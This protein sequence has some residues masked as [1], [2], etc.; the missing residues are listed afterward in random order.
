MAQD[1]YKILEVD[2]NATEADIKKAYRRLA[3]KH[4]PDVN[5]ND[6]QAEKK[7]KDISEA[8]Q[9]LSDPKKRQEYDMY[10]SGGFQGGQGF[11][12]G[13]GGFEYQQGGFD[14]GGGGGGFGDIFETLFGGGRGGA[15]SHFRRPARGED[16]HL[17]LAVSFD[18]AFKGVEKDISFQGFDP[19]GNCGGSG[20]APG[21]SCGKCGGSGSAPAIKRMSVKI[22]AGVD[23]GSKIRIPGKGRPGAAG[24]PTGDLYIITQVSPHSLF[25][26]KGNNLYV[27]LPVTI[28]EAA[29]GALLEVPTPE[30]K[31]SIKIPEGTDTGK[32]FRL[33]GKGF[34][35]LQNKGRGDLYVKIKTATPRNLSKADRE[36]LRKFAES[37]PEDPRAALYAGL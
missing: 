8:Y 15:A 5:P 25:E 35:S 13:G 26:R 7:F 33:R 23:N 27:E 24:Q 10:G 2:K 18:E 37:H 34:P 29:L 20:S 21:S 4:H 28:V 14:F 16:I 1:F 31:S 12:P 22:P 36:L 17:S 11:P 19:C 30:G 6:P 3:R 32:T 9:T